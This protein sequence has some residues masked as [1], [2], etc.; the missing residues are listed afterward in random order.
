MSQTKAHP[1]HLGG[2]AGSADAKAVAETASHL[3]DRQTGSAIPAPEDGGHAKSHAAH[4]H[5][6]GDAHTK[7]AGNLRQGSGPG[8]LREPPQEVSRVGKGHHRE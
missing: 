3:E 6:E 1:D 8:E 5:T 2:H 4:L 7:P